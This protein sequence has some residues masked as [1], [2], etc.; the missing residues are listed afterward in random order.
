MATTGEGKQQLI[1]IYIYCKWLALTHSCTDNCCPSQFFVRAIESLLSDD[2]FKLPSPSA[3]E[4]YGHARQLLHWYRAQDSPHNAAMFSSFASDLVAKLKLCFPKVMP[5][6]S[7]SISASREA[8]W[9]NYHQFRCSQEF[10]TKW[11]RFLQSA[12]HSEST[13]I[14]YQFITEKVFEN[15]LR[16]HFPLPKPTP[17]AKETDLTYEERNALRYAAGYIPRA[18]TKKLKSSS[19]PIRKGM[20]ICLTEMTNGPDAVDNGDDSEDWLRQI[21]RGGLNHANSKLYMV[22]VAME[23]VLQRLLRA[24]EVVQPKLKARAMEEILQDEDVLFNWSL[25][26]A[27]WETEEEEALLPLVSNMWITA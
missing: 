11:T 7:S 2:G 20:I 25:L 1:V 3:K 26:S 21:D 10:H 16:E 4:A 5:S 22:V 14:F 27:G 17:Q 18:L 12:L 13:P 6:S 23:L 15:L 9:R 24:P 19:H 8:L